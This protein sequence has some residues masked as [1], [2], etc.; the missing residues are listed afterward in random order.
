ML[1]LWNRRRLLKDY[2]V[3]GTAVEPNDSANASGN[4]LPLI[5]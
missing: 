5:V 1:L 2:T 3:E 4:T